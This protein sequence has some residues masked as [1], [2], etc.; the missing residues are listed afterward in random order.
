MNI[1][2]L[3]S[4]K[5]TEIIPEGFISIDT[6]ENFEKTL[7][8][9]IEKNKNIIINLKNTDF[10]DSSSI[11]LLI[12]NLKTAGLKG[13]KLIF[14]EPNKTVYKTFTIIGMIN[15]LTIARTHDEAVELALSD[16]K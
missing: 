10:I 13:L 2:I 15:T 12:M 16:N 9:H 3:E 6:M 14:S 7:S 8:N 5:Y 11:G 1:E 4:E